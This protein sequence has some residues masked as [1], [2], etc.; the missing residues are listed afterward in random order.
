MNTKSFLL[1]AAVLMLIAPA[2]CI[3]SPDE[4]GPGDQPGPG[5]GSE[6]PFPDSETQL[7]ENFREVYE[8]MDFDGYEA[9]LHRDFI[10][11]LQ[12]GTQEEF[13]NVGPTLDREEE[14]DIA[15][16]MFS[17][18]AITNSQGELVPGISSINFELFEQRGA[19]AT[20]PASDVIP[21]ARF[22]QFEVRFLFDRGSESTLRVDGLIKFYVVSRDSTSGGVTR[23]YFQMIGQQD[24]TNGPTP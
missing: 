13:P 1:L 14:I 19:W 22:A 8:N 18:N 23:P 7:M 21:N 4:P 12:T 2:G 6:L 15:Q 20:S 11:L 16:K 5:G 17:G 24:Q 3:F 9:M 10:T